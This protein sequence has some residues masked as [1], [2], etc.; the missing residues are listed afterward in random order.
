MDLTVNAATVRLSFDMLDVM[1]YECSIHS[2]LWHSSPS[3]QSSK[4]THARISMLQ[5]SL[6]A[7][8]NFARSLLATPESS[9]NGLTFPIWSGWFYSNLLVLKIIV[10]QKI[11]DTGSARVNSVPHTVGDL[12][13]QDHGGSTTRRISTMTS[14]LELATLRESITSLEEMEL[15]SLLGS[16]IQKLEAVAPQYAAEDLPATRKPYLT[17]VATLQTAL[18]E[19]IKKMTSSNP[20]NV[21]IQQSEYGVSTTDFSSGVPPNYEHQ[22]ALNG[23]YPD[24]GSMNHQ[25]SF[26][27]ANPD[28]MAQFGFQPGQQ[29]LVDD[30]L[31]NMVLNDGN[32]FTT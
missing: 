8:Q 6:L 11:G 24:L 1:V 25:S 13:P 15:V 17:K 23:Q 16:F 14:S 19:G 9:L 30:W 27:F 7:S 4:M 10:L 5:R 20:D 2:T 18:L 3:D 21:Y 26:E 12:L 28:T 31:W 32:M 22:H 29:P